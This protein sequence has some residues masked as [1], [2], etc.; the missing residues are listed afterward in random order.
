M[1]FLCDGHVMNR[2]IRVSVTTGHQAQ[3]IV[4][5]ALAFPLVFGFLCDCHVT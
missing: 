5:M 3:H 2:G 1:R 4:A